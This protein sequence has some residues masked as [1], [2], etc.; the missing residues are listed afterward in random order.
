MKKRIAIIIA[1]VAVLLAVG[2]AVLLPHVGR[3]TPWEL[4]Q[5][6][7]VHAVTGTAEEMAA[8]DNPDYPILAAENDRFQLLCRD[9]GMFCV[10]NKETGTTYASNPLEAD[11]KATGINK[12][13]MSSQLYIT[14]ANDGGSNQVKNSTVECVNKGWL[15]YAPIENGIRYSYDFQKA[16]II[17]PVEYVLEE[18]GL[19][20]SV[21]VDEIQE[22]SMGFYLTEVSLLPYFGASIAGSEGYFLVPDGSGALIHHDNEK[23][24]YGAYKQAVYSRDAAMIVE[25]LVAEDQAARLPVFGMKS[26]NAGYLAVID[27]GDGV[28]YVNAMTS[29]HITSYNNAYASFRFRLFTMLTYARSHDSQQVLMLASVRPEKLDYSVK[30][31]LLEQE[32]LDYVDMAAAYREHLIAN[33]GLTSR[34][35]KDEAPFYLE[36]LGGVQK[37]SVILGMKLNLLQ[38]LTTF[39]ETQQILETLRKNGMEDLLVRYTGWQ[40]GGV[41]SELNTKVSF[42]SALGGED[43]YQAL[44]EYADQ[45]GVELFMDFDM[46]NLYRSGNGVSSFMDATQTIQ[47]TPT[48]LYTYDYN[49][50]DKDPSTRWQLVTPKMAAAAVE[51]VLSNQDRLLG[52]NLSLSTMGD[53]LYSDFTDKSSGIDRSNSRVLWGEML[54]MADEKTEKLLVDGGNAYALPYVSHVYDAPMKCTMYDI[55][56]EAVPFYQ[57]VLHGY[58]SYST[59]PLNLSSN[60]EALVLKALETGSSLSACLMWAENHALGDTNLDYVFS[61]NYETWVPMLSE[62]YAKVTPILQAV[63]DATIVEHQCLQ[64]DVYKTVY[65]DGSVVYVNYSSKDAAVE[66]CIVPAKDFVYQPG[67]EVQ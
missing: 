29:G 51:K 14:Y 54:K 10:I 57:I 20:A 59:E 37:E 48:Y 23:A 12:T 33:Y 35:Q 25:N 50:L 4:H 36:M 46:F 18:D 61:G 42:E 2:V 44:V 8:S 65:S 26:G 64:M 67:K 40:K 62:A 1:A 32:N 17:I 38:K 52:A 43:G 34:V 27:S 6:A 21:V 13:N 56:D 15:T 45:H 24:V 49:T 16:G 19:R 58:V 39:S 55:E 9:D 11:S 41:E 63:A 5:T 53:T 3:L 31:I 66:G 47:H 28:G 60:P 30:Y 22:G 7:P